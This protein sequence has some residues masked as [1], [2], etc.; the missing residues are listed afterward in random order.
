M[1][2]YGFAQFSD[3]KRDLYLPINTNDAT[4]LA[5]DIMNGKTAY[6]LQSKI[7]GTNTTML[8]MSDANAN[9]NAIRTGKTAYVLDKKITGVNPSK[10]IAYGTAVVA[11]VSGIMK[12][13]ISGLA[14]QPSFLTTFSYIEDAFNNNYGI[15]RDDYSENGFATMLRWPIGGG[16]LNAAFLLANVNSSGSVTGNV[17]DIVS[18][19]SDGFVITFN[20]LG[21]T[22]AGKQFSYFVME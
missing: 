17:R 20:N 12:S 21:S 1:K 18:F 22:S 16:A 7:T 3:N 13:T 10:R 14:F 2:D 4:A 6:V 11:N 9:E 5:S 19:T 15:I 8:D